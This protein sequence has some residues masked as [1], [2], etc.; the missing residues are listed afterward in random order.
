MGI[1]EALHSIRSLSEDL[2]KLGLKEG[3]TVIV[4]SSLRAIGRVIGGPVSVL[5]SIEQFLTDSGNLAMQ[6]VI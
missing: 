5:L 2:N 3:D 6:R 4:H 1:N